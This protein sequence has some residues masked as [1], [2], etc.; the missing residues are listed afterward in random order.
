MKACRVVVCALVGA[1]LLMQS[2]LEGASPTIAW[3]DMLLKQPPTKRALSSSPRIDLSLLEERNIY[4]ERFGVVLCWAVVPRE[5]ARVKVDDVRDTADSTL[6][7]Y[8]KVAHPLD[9]AVLNGGFY[10][11]DQRGSRI[12]LG[13][14][15]SQGVVRNRLIGWKTG[16]VLEIGARLDIVPIARF[17]QRREIRAAVQ[18]KPL[19]VEAGKVAIHSKGGD[20]ANRS[21]IGLTPEGDV[22]LAGAFSA[23]NQAMTLYEFAEFL[24]AGPASGGPDAYIALA[25]DGGPG[26]HIYFP[27][28]RHHCG[29]DGPNY[30]PNVVRVSLA[31]AGN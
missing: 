14:V 20:L 2:Q 13:L 15:I 31:T 19:V 25:M 6:K 30:V 22:I 11:L 16:G 1:L 12:P 26:A 17:V 4:S 5:A 3:L 7:L 28:A 10:G 24:A 21:A 9:I 23:T 18:S 27:G 8:E 29:T